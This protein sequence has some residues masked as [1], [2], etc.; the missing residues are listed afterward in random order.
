MRGPGT[1]PR[2]SRYAGVP[3]RT[4]RFLRLA[5]LVVIGVLTVLLL[6]R[7]RVVLMPFVFALA[8]AYLLAPAVR[9]CERRG[10]PTW[11][12]ILI[13]Y[14]AVGVTVGGMGVVV[15]PQLAAEGKELLAALPAFERRLDDLAALFFSHYRSL[16][17]PPA[18]RTQTDGIIAGLDGVVAD[19]LRRA[20]KGVAGSLPVLVSLVIAP[21]LAYYVLRDRRRFSRQL[22][23]LV[24]RHKRRSVHRL[25][26]DLDRAVGGFVRGQIVI[27]LAIG[28]MA[29]AVSLLF[30]LPFPLFIGLVAAATDI[31]PYLGPLL[32]ALPAVTFALLRSPAEALW[33]LAVFLAMHEFEGVVLS[34]WILGSEVGMHPLAI[35]LVILIGGDLFGFLGMLIAVPAAAALAVLSTFAYRE[36]TAWSRRGSWGRPVT[37][38]PV[39]ARSVRFSSGR[40]SGRMVSGKT[41]LPQGTAPRVTT[42]RGP[43]GTHGAK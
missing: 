20:L 29:L 19:V 8:L 32:G 15:V 28:L 11:L 33:V 13:V 34:P 1:V 7:V 36:V 14:A 9:T 21:F 37:G 41:A 43:R 18:M 22:V 27:S 26:R 25:V 2:S 17:L 16:P 42:G 23:H 12:A 6:W 10:V 40:A 5:T 3:H 30:R 39:R 31:I 35:F 24:P 4:R 38:I